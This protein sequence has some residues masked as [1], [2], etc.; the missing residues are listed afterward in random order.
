MQ[1][2]SNL[3]I[4]ANMQSPRPAQLF[5]TNY[6][7]QLIQHHGSDPCKAPPPDADPL[8]ACKTINN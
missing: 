1:K 3:L 2:D 6:H 4:Q 7:L 8:P 5:Y